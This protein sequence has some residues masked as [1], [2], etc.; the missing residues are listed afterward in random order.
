MPRRLPLWLVMCALA[1]GCYDLPDIE[2]D[3]CGNKV[4]DGEE[5]CDGFTEYGGDTLCGAPDL[6]AEA[7]RCVYLCTGDSACPPGWGCG[8]DGVCSRPEGTF[9]YSPLSPW[10]MPVDELA[11]GD[12]DGDGN[13]DLIGNDPAQIVVRFGSA[14]AEFPDELV[15]P[16]RRPSGAVTYTHFDDD[17]RLDAIVPIDL[18]LFVLRGGTGRTL[19][20]IAYSPFS[21]GGYFVEFHH[22]EHP[23]FPGPT[24]LIVDVVNN[25]MAFLSQSGDELYD[26][27]APPG[28]AASGLILP[29]PVADV[30]GVPLR[31]EFV[32]AYYNDD[33]VHLYTTTGLP[34][35]EDTPSTLEPEPFQDLSLPANWS[36]YEGTLFADVDGANGPD[37]IISGMYQPPDG[38]EELGVLVAYNNGSTLNAPVREVR[39]E[40]A[41][42]LEGLGTNLPL[43]AADF[44]G[45]GMADYATNLGVMMSRGGGGAGNPPNKL[46]LVATSLPDLWSDAAIG[47]FNGDGMPDVAVAR[48]DPQNARVLSGVDLFLDSPSGFFNP[49]HLQTEGGGPRLYPRSFM[50]GDYDGDLIDDVAFFQELPVADSPETPL[51][52][53][54]GAADG[55]FADAAVMGRFRGYAQMTASTAALSPASLDGITDLFVTSFDDQGDT[56]QGSS[57]SVMF[58]DS[59]RRMVAPLIL[60]PSLVTSGA[61]TAPQQPRRALVG[62]FNEDHHQDLLVL[63]DD[64][65]L[66]GDD[67]H[68]FIW[69]IPG[70]TGDGS[71]D[72]TAAMYTDL[73]T[74]NAVGDFNFGCSTWEVVDLEAGGDRSPVELLG[75]DDS[76]ACAFRDEQNAASE[77]MVVK[78]DPSSDDPMK[79]NMVSF[80]GDL[81]YP[82]QLSAADFDD[83]GDLDPVVLFHGSYFVV[84]DPAGDGTDM[85]YGV[86][87]AGVGILWNDGAKM[88]GDDGIID[89]G[90][91]A[92]VPLPD[93]VQP[94]KVAALA[95]NEDAHKDLIILTD[96]GVFMALRD[97]EDPRSFEA[98]VSIDD[99]SEGRLL[100]AGDVN[101]DG[102]TDFAVVAGQ[103]VS[104][105]LAVKAPRKGADPRFGQDGTTAPQTGVG[106]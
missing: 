92:A 91:Y 102:L 26:P 8:L 3:V 12:V 61:P 84:D 105:L 14:S 93:G 75:L 98:P 18:G 46:D 47:D 28:N 36:I 53:A 29:P 25:T 59:S 9:E 76:S 49:F 101:G 56:S 24:V 45:D 83:D 19:D 48:F 97:P 44:D 100:G 71:V 63:A 90:E 72:P 40:N 38:P 37:L 81:T 88:G 35:T 11:I 16:I 65:L 99:L 33:A 50:V 74:V 94:I 1:A 87:G 4:I 42:T 27:I 86:A 57:I 13:A 52:V 34:G 21:S 32:L 54:F 60:D 103:N 23:F 15:T 69:Y 5:D 39:L 58:G 2:P 80:A 73:N 22:I 104:V 70:T 62:D 66:G 106:E 20:S 82:D 7:Q 77:I 17:D 95:I 6:E 68:R 64:A 67:V 43:A 78:V 31:P 89:Q 85:G 41:F 55:R 79:M 51:L 10:H 30:N 96:V